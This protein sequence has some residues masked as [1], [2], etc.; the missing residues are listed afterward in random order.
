MF[1]YILYKMGQ[2]VA[3]RLPRKVAYKVA[4]FISDLHYQF[5]FKDRRIVSD[6]LKAIFPQKNNSQICRIRLAVFRNF[7]KHLVDFFRFAEVDSEFIEKFIKLENL[8]YLREGFSKGKGV[9]ALSAHLGSWELGGAAFGVLGYPFWVVALSHNHAKVN[10]FFNLQR[11]LKGMKVLQLGR[12]FRQCIRVIKDN[13][14]IGLVGDR[15]FDGKGVLA[16]FFGKP[17]LF[18]EGPAAL[19]LKYGAEIIPGFM[20]RNQDDSFTF[21]M[22]RPIEFTP[23]GNH[24]EDMKALVKKY[25]VVFESYIREFPDQWY[26]FRRFWV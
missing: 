13:Q 18:P 4:V 11:E 15:N 2:F 19:S 7:A 17:T 3:M 9:I 23:S 21:R 1:N 25:K 12:A 26:M 10:N 14:M 24:Q 22:E 20:I 8:D 6:N 16:D 5:A